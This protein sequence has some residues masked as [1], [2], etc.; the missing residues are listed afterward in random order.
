M[1]TKHI[2]TS[3]NKFCAILSNIIKADFLIADYNL[4]K[5]ASTYSGSSE[6]V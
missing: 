3:L 5:I 6:P 4:R 2:S 1:D